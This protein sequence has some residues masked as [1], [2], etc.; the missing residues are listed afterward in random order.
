VLKLSVVER[1]DLLNKDVL[2]VVDGIAALVKGSEDE[3]E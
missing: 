2:D 3:K 1:H